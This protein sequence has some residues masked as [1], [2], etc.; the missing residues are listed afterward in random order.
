MDYPHS[1]ALRLARCL[2]LGTSLVWAGLSYAGP[3][4]TLFT[5]GGLNAPVNDI[6]VHPSGLWVAVST[7]RGVF[8]YSTTDAALTAH[9]GPELAPGLPGAQ[10]IRYSPEGNWAAVRFGNTIR[11]YSTPGFT[12]YG[13]F[14]ATGGTPI[15]Q[16]TNRHL[17]VIGGSIYRTS[18]FQPIA[19]TYN[20][21]PVD[22][23]FIAWLGHYAYIRSD[24]FG[25]F[26]IIGIEGDYRVDRAISVGLFGYQVFGN[27]LGVVP[28]Y[29]N[30]NFH[31]GTTAFPGIRV[32]PHAVG[33]ASNPWTTFASASGSNA[34]GGNHRFSRDGHFIVHRGY[35]EP[36][37]VQI[38]NYD[39]ER[40]TLTDMYGYGE[41][42][43]GQEAVAAIHAPPGWQL[44]DVF[45]A[46]ATYDVHWVQINA[47][48]GEK[49]KLF[50]FTPNV[51][52]VPRVAFSPNGSELAAGVYNSLGSDRGVWIWN[53][54]TNR[55]KRRLTTTDTV[56]HLAY[57]DGS[58]L[59][60]G[61]GE[62]PGRLEVW[63]RAPGDW[64]LER[65][66]ETGRF[67]DL[68]V[69]GARAVVLLSQQ[70]LWTLDPTTGL[71]T[72]SHPFPTLYGGTI[73]VSPSGRFVAQHRGGYFDVVLRR[74]DDLETATQLTSVP[75]GGV[76]MDWSPD[77]RTL[78][79]A[80]RSASG[81]NTL[82]LV[83]T[84]TGRARERTLPNHV[85]AV[86]FVPNRNTIVAYGALTR[87]AA[88]YDVQTLQP[89]AEY[90]ARIL[91]G[92]L[93]Q[94]LAV[95]PDGTKTAYG[96]ADG[97]IVVATNPGAPSVQRERWSPPGTRG[98][99]STVR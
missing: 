91:G 81:E 76:A 40:I 66:I 82:R 15:F 68:E 30:H 58:R 57:L 59:L 51:G 47:N 80:I 88:H 79:L 93:K 50:D 34:S 19:L 21:S 75:Q 95:S 13:H 97:P 10:A 54:A 67:Q 2:G 18:D 96:S 29:Q 77:G 90:D 45:M 92:G 8:E 17:G 20:G 3:P 65:T 74:T 84:S 56:T 42:V 37:N 31:L 22:Y 86:R 44:G 55:P 69:A 98:N 28:P 71:T 5:I 24:P 70:R 26:Y 36:S 4:P 78:A 25:L 49:W 46:S 9:V 32:Y 33:N 60:V 1:I 64:V 35:A 62:S 61:H 16:G 83:D 6:D 73:A 85:G 14:S 41:H 43:R 87:W 94:Q 63:R 89:I 11:I 23:Q 39:P 12:F 72:S 38:W 27:D 53:V 48:H 7:G 99:Q 52:G